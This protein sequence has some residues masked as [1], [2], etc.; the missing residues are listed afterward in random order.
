MM[1]KIFIVFILVIITICVVEILRRDHRALET[2][3]YNYENEYNDFMV[4]KVQDVKPNLDMIEGSVCI[5]I[6]TRNCG[7]YMSKN[8]STL[9]TIR[10]CFSV[11]HVVFYE[12]G[13]TDNTRTKLSEYCDK[14]KNSRLIHED[15]DS[16]QYPRTVRL[17]RGRNICL[18]EARKINPEYFICLDFDDAIS[19]LTKD[20]FM[21]CFDQ[22]FHWDM[23]SANQE[24]R[25]YDLWALRT[26]DKWMDYDYRDMALFGQRSLYFPG[27]LT[28][29][30]KNIKETEVIPV[31]SSFGGIAIYKFGSIEDGYYYGYKNEKESC[32]HVHL[33]KQMEAKGK[34]LF[35]LGSFISS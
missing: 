17:A 8:L 3:E 35:I 14:N 28:M 12:N 19:E 13:S 11:S 4:E 2:K 21:T 22:D 29:K 16:S 24:G 34:K 6:C 32:E 5:G 1:M 18:A 10:S 26:Y 33:H 25:Y 9:D 7:T 30:R 20:R 15:Y 23:L 27:Y 31:I